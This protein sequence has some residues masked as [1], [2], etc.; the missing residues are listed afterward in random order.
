M[1]VTVEAL[2]L[3]NFLFECFQLLFYS[4]LEH[5]TCMFH[6]QQFIEMREVQPFEL[7]DLNTDCGSL[8]L[9]VSLPGIPMACYQKKASMPGFA[10]T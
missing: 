4:N 2:H 8:H 5:E 10:G 9:S 1:R 7:G 3:N 6:E